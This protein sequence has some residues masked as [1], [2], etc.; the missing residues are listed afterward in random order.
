MEDLQRNPVDVLVCDFCLFGAIAAG[1]AS[2]VPSAVIVHNAFPFQPGRLPPARS[3][4]EALRQVPERWMLRRIWERDGLPGYNQARQSL[5]LAPVALSAFAQSDRA[6][7]VLVLGYQWFDFPSK[8]LHPNI[9]YV[10]T[11][12]DDAE[13][14]SDAWTSPWPVD[15]P[16]PL[17]LVSMSTLPQGQGPA[18]HNI[19]AA[20]SGMPI[21][22][23]VTLGPSMNE[24]DFE[25][26]DNIRFE[27]FVPHSAVLPHA[28]AIVSQCGLS[29][30]TKA[31][32]HGVPLLCMPILGDQPTN[33]ARIAAHGAGLWLDADA[34]PEDIR[35]ALARLLDEP[36]F[37]EA[38]ARLASRMLGDKAEERAAA[39][40]E[41]L[42]HRESS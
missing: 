27:K 15:D 38:A 8:D 28:S 19:V 18:L 25:A 20:I 17:V 29:T 11:P 42:A 9:R 36:S 30:L 40:L 39:E 16:R 33:A 32:R 37:R 34:P 3:P 35:A 6:E 5:G 23:L 22:A 26:P 24:E 7:R 1:E 14:T 2:R 4:L 41:A 10:G 31:L 21:R 13:V 12:I